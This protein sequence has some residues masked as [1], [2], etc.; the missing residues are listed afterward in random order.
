MLGFDNRIAG[1]TNAGAIT[2]EVWGAQLEDI[3]GQSNTNP[4]EYVSVGVLSAPYHG[5]GVDGV[6][7][8]STLNGNTVV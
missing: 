4:G 7:Y 3:T 1:Q 2:V 8:F 5:A 6:K